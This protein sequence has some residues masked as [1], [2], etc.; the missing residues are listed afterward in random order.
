MILSTRF[1]LVF[2]FRR[3][4]RWP[5]WILDQ[6]NFSNFLSTSHHDTSYQ[7][8]S[9]LAFWFRRRCSNSIFKT[10]A[11]AA[12]LDYASERFSLFFYL[13]K[14]A[15]IFPTKFWVN[16]PLCLK[17]AVQNRYSRWQRWR[18]SWISDRNNFTY[19]LS[20]T[21][22]QYN[23]ASFESI[24][25]SVQEKFKIDF[26]DG[27]HGGKFR[28]PF[29]AIGLS[30]Q[31]KKFKKDFQDCYYG[32]HLGFWIWAIL[33]IFLSTNHL[34]VSYQVSSQ[35]VFRFSRRSEKQFFKMAAMVAILDFGS[36]RF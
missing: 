11:M 9:Q 13:L 21:S 1:Q 26:Q 20:T 23:L 31:E 29:R 36:D 34:D 17:E 19:F 16:W 10:V 5:F 4:S 15:L 12:I 30:V 22:P 14:V 28:F 25:L 32:G 6:N 2:P 18:P 27:G 8:L 7:R 3:S 24:G 33:A 35:L